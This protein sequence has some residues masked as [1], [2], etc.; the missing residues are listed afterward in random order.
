MYIPS[1][2]YGRPNLGKD[3]CIVG[4]VNFGSEPYLVSIGAGT[5]IS[6]DC[7]FVTHDAATRVIR[8]LPD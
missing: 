1:E 5:T 4:E 8:N 6:F 3:V 7:A 2:K